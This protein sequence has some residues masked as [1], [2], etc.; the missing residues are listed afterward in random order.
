[1]QVL[2]QHQSGRPNGFLALVLMLTVLAGCAT[3]PKPIKDAVEEKAAVTEET[4]VTHFDDG[5]QGF[6]IR[7]MSSMDG[8]ARSD[9][10]AAVVLLK[11]E[12]YDPAIELLEK[13]IAAA[14]GVSAPYINAALA[15]GETGKPEKAEGHLKTALSLVPGHPAASNVYGLLLRKGGRFAEAREI[16]E[17]ALKV[18]PEYLPARKN[19]GIL[20]DLYLDDP[21]CA[22]EQYEIY[23]QAKP[24]EEQVSIWVADLRLRLGV[25]Q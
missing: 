22:L 25:Q 5:R 3:A 16:Y 7:E 2:I 17:T 1:M 9:F 4:S 20:C 10:A 6:V 24:E 12:K 8:E 19:L 13:V 21:S 23:S 14:P 15:Y 18:F 11:E